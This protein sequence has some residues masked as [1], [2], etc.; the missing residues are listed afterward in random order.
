MER[1]ERRVHRDA[2]EIELVFQTLKHESGTTMTRWLCELVS[3]SLALE[4]LNLTIENFYSSLHRRC[5][6]S[7]RLALFCALIQSYDACWAGPARFFTSD[8]TQRP[9]HAIES[10]DR[11]LHFNPRC[12]HLAWPALPLHLVPSSG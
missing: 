11:S 10:D 5:Q 7:I 1:H 3:G 12:N 8:P 6:Q 4:S 2:W 9:Y